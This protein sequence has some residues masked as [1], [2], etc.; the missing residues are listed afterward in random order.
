M[1]HKIKNC[2]GVPIIVF[3][4]NTE[5]PTVV[6]EMYIYID[7]SKTQYF[8]FNN[9]PWKMIIYTCIFLGNCKLTPV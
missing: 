6:S 1:N 9:S 7:T 2:G 3:Q 8:C 5:Y 4:H